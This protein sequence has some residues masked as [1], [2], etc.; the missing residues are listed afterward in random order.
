MPYLVYDVE[1]TG[2]EPGYHE[3]IQLGAVLY[4]DRWEVIDTYLSNVYPQYPD[5][6]SIPASAVHNLTVADLDDAPMIYEVIEDF[7]G[8]ILDQVGS[9][10]KQR[11]ELRN[12]V[13]CGQN[14]TTDVNFMRF[15]YR[16]AKVSWEFSHRVL[17][18][19]VLANFYFRI[20]R[21]NKIGV[22]KSLALG[23]IAEFFGLA[24]ADEAH[25]ALEDSILTG[26]CIR[27]ILR[28]ANKFKVA[29]DDLEHF[30]DEED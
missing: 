27:I 25:N 16:E 9:V 7:E 1:T 17:D 20:L 23:A 8:W 19:F 30:D 13:V 2:L 12:I 4:N 18:L 14:V 10:R 3:I 24:R 22:P 21:A 29:A 6:F 5:R 15:A 11:D 26:K 28:N